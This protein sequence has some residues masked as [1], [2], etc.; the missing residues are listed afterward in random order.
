LSIVELGHFLSLTWE[1]GVLH[2]LTIELERSVFRD[3]KAVA[4]EDGVSPAEAVAGIVE[5]FFEERD[6]PSDDGK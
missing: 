6:N 4:T 2:K 5:D 3:L 1:V